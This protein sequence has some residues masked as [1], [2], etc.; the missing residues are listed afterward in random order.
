GYGGLRDYLG[1]SAFKI[2]AAVN[3]IYFTNEKYVNT[4]T[5]NFNMIVAENAC[6]FSGIQYTQG[7]YNFND[8]DKHLEFAEKNNMELRGH[9]LIWHAYP[10]SWF[11]KI[12][13]DTV[14]NKTIVNHITKVLTH[15]QGK[16]KI[17]DVVNEAID[18]GTPSDEFKFRK[19]F[20]YNAL[21]N[22]VDI[23]FQTA[24]EVDPS[25][26]L[27]YND[28]NIEGGLSKSEATYLFVKDLVKRG[29]PIDGVGFQYH[30]SIKFQPSLETVKETIEKYCQLGLEVHITEMDVKCEANCDS[31]N[32]D[33]LQSNVYSNALNACLSSSCCTAFLV[34]G[35]NDSNTW[36]SPEQKPLLFDTSYNPKPQYTAL[37]NILK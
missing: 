17:W 10:P 13:T 24:R 21:P 12:T 8:C 27:F 3:S 29:I 26:K 18:D 9:C 4:T 37:L 14:M 28:Y 15:Y 16:I 33:Q 1:S 32:V 6:K 20:L 23:A 35:I 11:E 25:V 19:S 5:T 36:I 7:V 22:F 2:G 31:S 34:W 30:V